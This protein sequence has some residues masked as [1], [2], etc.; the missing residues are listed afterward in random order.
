MFTDFFFMVS[1]NLLFVKTTTALCTRFYAPHRAW[2]MYFHL[3]EHQTEIKVLPNSGKRNNIH[4]ALL[5]KV[6]ISEHSASLFLLSKTLE[7]KCM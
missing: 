6:L 7:I 2:E 4:K 1:S 5:A 3:N